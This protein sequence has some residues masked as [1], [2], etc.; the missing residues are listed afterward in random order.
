MKSYL[1]DIAEV[2]GGEVL[3]TIGYL[4][5]HLVL[6]H[7]VL[8]GVSFGWK[9]RRGSDC[10]AY[11]VMIASETDDDETVFLCGGGQLCEAVSQREEPGGGD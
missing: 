4:V 6:P 10:I 3:D 7:A 2:D 5:Q 11:R 8:Y 9:L 1:V